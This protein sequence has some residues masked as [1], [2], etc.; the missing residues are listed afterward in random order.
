MLLEAQE[1]GVHGCGEIAIVTGDT[2]RTGH[3]EAK[4]IRWTTHIVSAPM[5]EVVDGF[6]IAAQHDAHAIQNFTEKSR[7][8]GGME[9]NANFIIGGRT[10]TGQGQNS[11]VAR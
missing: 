11:F 5:P 10:N 4:F 1:V 6:G 7:G 2:I 9:K 3:R 8:N